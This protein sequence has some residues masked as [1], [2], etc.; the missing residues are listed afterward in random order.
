[1]GSSRINTMKKTLAYVIGACIVLIVGF[2]LIFSKSSPSATAPAME[3]NTSTGSEAMNSNQSSTNS[4]SSEA[5]IGV[6]VTAS[7]TIGATG[8]YADGTYTGSVADAIYGKLQVVAT[9]QGG[10]I[11]NIT[12]PVYP[13]EAGHTAQVSASA[14]PQLKQEA[15]TSQSANVSVV[16]G[17]TQTS[18][19]FQQ[20]LAAALSQA[21]S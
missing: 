7:A 12:W 20:S 5:G 4:T 16:S 21:K 14:L 13:N 6:G 1:M 9:I 19:A 18:D 10:A 15:I 17:A 11:T 2:Y 3:N 8:Q